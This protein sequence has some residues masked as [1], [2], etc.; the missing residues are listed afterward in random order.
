M[1]GVCE[2]GETLRKAREAKGLS[3]EEAARKTGVRLEYLEALESC[4]FEG[5]PEPGLMRAHLR[6]LAR[7][8]DLDPEALAALYPARPAPA[9]PRAPVPAPRRPGRRPRGLWLFLAL[10][11]AFALGAY[12]LWPK[13]APAPQPEDASPPPQTPAAPVAPET[14]PPPQRVRLR[15]ETEPKEAE[16]YLDGYYLGPAPVELEVEAGRRLLRIEAEGYLP[17]E[18]I[19]DLERDQRL[20]VRLTKKPEEKPQESP[21]PPPKTL[22]LKVAQKSWLRVTTPEGKKLYEKTAPPGTELTFELPVVVRVGNAGGVRAVLGGR[23]LGPLGKPGEVKTL[24]FEAPK[25]NE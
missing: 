7:F 25:E 19:L 3:L 24:R 13:G 6:R 23:D 22:T 20:Q 17:H 8:F 12:L 4:R 10:L 21:P 18:Q 9:P 2:L 16:V 11:F 1:D 14:P 15:V 5:L